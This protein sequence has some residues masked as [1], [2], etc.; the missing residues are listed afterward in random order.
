M[1]PTESRRLGILTSLPMLSPR[2]QPQYTSSTVNHWSSP[3]WLKQHPFFYNNG[4]IDV[5]LFE[6]S[7]QALRQ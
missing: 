4:H 5:A 3:P 7:G 1:Y 6:L 2:N